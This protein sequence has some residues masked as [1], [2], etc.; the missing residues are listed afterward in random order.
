MAFN[1]AGD[2]HEW[3][4]VKDT[5]GGSHYLYQST[6]PALCMSGGSAKP[7]EIS[8]R[9]S[10]NQ[11]EIQTMYL[12]N[13]GN[14]QLIQGYIL[15]KHDIKRPGILIRINKIAETHFAHPVFCMHESTENS[16]NTVY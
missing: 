14:D 15:G 11:A 7:K 3:R 4:K 8:V 10:G 2:D 5:K 1:E 6:V 9:T 13:T 16:Q 12:P